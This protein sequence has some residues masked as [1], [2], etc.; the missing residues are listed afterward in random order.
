MHSRIEDLEDGILGA[1]KFTGAVTLNTAIPT[2]TTLLGAGT[3]T[4]RY[5]MGTTASQSAVGIFAE[6]TATTGDTRNINARLYFSGVGGSGECLRAYG[7]VNN[8]TAATLGTVNG[9]HVSLGITGTNGKVSGAGNA[10]R[11][12]LDLGANTVSGGTLSVIQADTN[13][14]T[15]ST[16]PAGLAFM[17]M[18]DTGAKKASYGFRL[19]TVASAG[20]LAAHTTALITHSVR[21]IDEAGTVVYLMATTDAAQRTGGA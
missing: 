11:A 5:A 12:T 4:T 10:L 18:T 14:D 3:T 7:I 16:V 17:R 19:P 9:A 13:F 1:Y 6:T 8:V 20:L 21:C 15:D 2:T